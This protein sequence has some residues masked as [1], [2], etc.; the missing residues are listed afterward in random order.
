MTLD[1]NKNPQ[2]DN[3]MFAVT[4]EMKSSDMILKTVVFKQIFYFTTCLWKLHQLNN[5]FFTFKKKINLPCWQNTSFFP[6]SLVHCVELVY[7]HTKLDI[8]QISG[9]RL[10]VG[11]THPYNDGKTSS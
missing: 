7:M 2:S 5:F 4:I 10:N 8:T 1:L 9:S 11:C 6:I 3:D